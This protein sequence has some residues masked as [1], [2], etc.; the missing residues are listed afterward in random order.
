MACKKGRETTKAQRRRNKGDKKQRKKLGNER[1][2]SI[3][4]SR[5]ERNEDEGEGNVI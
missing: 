2:T 4:R 3:I 1:K 5:V